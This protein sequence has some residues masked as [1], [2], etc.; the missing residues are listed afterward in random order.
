MNPTREPKPLTDTEVRNAK[1]K[2][3]MFKLFDAGGGGLYLEVS[4]SGGKLWRFKYRFDGKQ[5]LLAL[6]KYPE[7][8]LS[9]ARERRDNARK[10]LANDSDPGAV[11]KAQKA[12]SLERSANTFRAVA[13]RWLESWKTGVTDKTARNA[14]RRLE[15]HIYPLLGE[16][17]I[18]D[19]DAPRILDVL[20][21]LEARGIHETI[22]QSRQAIGMILRYA[23]TRKLMAS[24][25]IHDIKG[26]CKPVPTKHHPALTK[27]SEVAELMRR[28]DGYTG[29]LETSAALK[30]LPLVFVRPGELRAM[31]WTDVDLDQAEWRFTA[32][33]TKT[34][35]LVP[36]ARQAVAILRELHSITGDNKYGLVFPG[37]KWGLP[38]SEATLNRA[39]QTLGYSTK[40]EMTGH[41]FRALARTLL[42]EELEF[43]PLILEHQ[44]GH[45]V[46]DTLGEAYSRTR[47]LPQRKA[48]M[49]QWADYLDKL[50]AGA[51][52]IPI[53]RNAV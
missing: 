26:E 17:P 27:P 30:L 25:P 4:P 9:D 1:P 13:E 32:S 48:M 11:K 21:V 36:L 22:K 44:L 6:G 35:R 18:A 3:K 23:V 24:N 37:T 41:G 31:K 16:C 2:E 29:H 40:E 47:Y 49:Q 52:I 34:E 45:R 28:I 14:Q 20:R 50:K 7:I 53:R 15:M 38:I 19:I 12:A 10:L 51:E 39:L 46:P 43:D 42:A 33:K 5:K 8:T